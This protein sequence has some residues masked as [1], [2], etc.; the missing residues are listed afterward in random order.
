[1]N[2]PSV[3]IRYTAEA[4]YTNTT[5]TKRCTDELPG[6]KNLEFVFSFKCYTHVITERKYSDVFRLNLCFN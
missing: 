1:M 2:Q 5:G 6:R 4:V 3:F